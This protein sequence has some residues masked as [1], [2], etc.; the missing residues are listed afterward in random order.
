MPKFLFEVTSNAPYP[1]TTKG[2]VE[3]TDWHVASTR[4]V[5]AH[6]QGLREKKKLRKAGKDMII[7]LW[8]L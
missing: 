8:K 2:D 4:A 5:K 7:K 3:C 6:R 1:I